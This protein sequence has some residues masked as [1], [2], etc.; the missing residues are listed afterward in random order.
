MDEDWRVT[1]GE[2]AENKKIFRIELSFL[3]TNRTFIKKLRSSVF[4]YKIGKV[5]FSTPNTITQNNN[6]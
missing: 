5:Q 4:D 2:S 6:A 1:G 3:F